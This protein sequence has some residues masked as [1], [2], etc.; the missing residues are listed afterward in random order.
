MVVTVVPEEPVVP[1]VL[2]DLLAVVIEV[3]AARVEKAEMEVLEVK[4]KQVQ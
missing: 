1:E 4:A 3:Q 2:Q